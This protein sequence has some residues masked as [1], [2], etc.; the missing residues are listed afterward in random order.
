MSRSETATRSVLVVGRA[1][2]LTDAIVQRFQHG[3]ASVRVARAELDEVVQAHPVDVLVIDVTGDLDSAALDRLADAVTWCQAAGG[4]MCERR[5]GVIVV[6]STADGYHSQ[7]GGAMRSTVQSGALGMVRGYG[8]EWASLGVRV[9]GVAYTCASGADGE[10]TPPIGRHPTT[11][12]VADAVE[13]M[14][15]ADASYIVAETL[16]VDGGFVAYQ[17]F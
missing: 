15:G 7:S 3:S 11:A 9:V 10:R 8:I 2:E 16:R 6:V 17:M 14:A 5:D 13:F 1:S 12:E 4:Q